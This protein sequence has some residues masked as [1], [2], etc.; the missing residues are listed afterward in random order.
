MSFFSKLWRGKK[1]TAPPVLAISIKLIVMTDTGKRTVTLH[2]LREEKIA[3]L[4]SDRS[5]LGEFI[6]AVAIQGATRGVP[7]K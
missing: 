6:E 3:E 4:L 1:P 2:Y 5:P 7:A